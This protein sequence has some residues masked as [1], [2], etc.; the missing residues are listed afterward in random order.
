MFNPFFLREHL[1]KSRQSCEGFDNKGVEA[2]NGSCKLLAVV[3]AFAGC[4]LGV[5][6]KS[7]KKVVNYPEIV[8]DFAPTPWPYKLG[9]SSCPG[10][11]TGGKAP[12]EVLLADVECIVRHGIRTVI[13]L[14]GT[15]E[16][17]SMGAESLPHHLALHD[18]GW[19]QLPVEDFGVPTLA[20]VARWYDLLPELTSMLQTAPIL[21]HCAH[22]KGRTG[23][24]VATLFKAWGWGSEEAIAWVR[25]YRNG[26]IEN[27][28][29]ET[30]VEAFRPLFRA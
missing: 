3:R 10:W 28:K 2:P 23:T 12:K 26:A 9:M 4:H 16:L 30:Y 18:I 17:E 14:L 8:I 27:L 24:M 19:H 7:Y 21:I 6:Q 29:Q 20:V 1:K 25:R 13:S 22:G 5:A 11:R 15:D